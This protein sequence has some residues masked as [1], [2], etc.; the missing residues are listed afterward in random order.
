M[1]NLILILSLF[2]CAG[3]G[4]GSGGNDDLGNEPGKESKKITVSF[5]LNGELTEDGENVPLLRS[6]TENSDLYGIQV[7]VYSDVSKQYEPYMSGVFDKLERLSFSVIEGDKY[8]IKATAIIDGKNVVKKTDSYYY[9][10]FASVLTNLFADSKV[11]MGGLYASYT[12]CALDGKGYDLPVT[13]R[14][15]GEVSDVVFDETNNYTT[16]S[17]KRLVFAVMYKVRNLKQGSL[18]VSLSDG[19]ITSPVFEISTDKQFIYTFSNIPQ[20]WEGWQSGYSYE[21]T[22]KVEY[23]APDNTV[24]LIGTKKMNVERR[25][26][27]S[28]TINMSAEPSFDLDFEEGE[29]EKGEDI[30]L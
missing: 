21:Y 6:G 5:K 2:I 15:Y 25:K 10:P 8:K 22:A 7:Y 4:A 9:Y 27:T 1:K 28:L 14:Y 3:C 24:Q 30:I 20:A 23:K 18:L 17:M 29:L 12:D 11:E 19:K 26:I 13:D 16:I